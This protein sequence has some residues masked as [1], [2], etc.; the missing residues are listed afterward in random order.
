MIKHKIG[1]VIASN[2]EFLILERNPSR[3]TGWG[4][5]TGTMED[6]EKPQETLVRELYEELSIRLDIASIPSPLQQTSYFCAR[7][8]ITI[9]INWFYIHFPEQPH[10]T[11]QQ[12]E[13]LNYAWLNKDKAIKLLTWDSE[14]EIFQQLI[15]EYFSR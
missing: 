13:W 9:V 3:Y 6:N 5:V 8:N 12:E 1:I 7:K 4:L 11:I 10:L 14:K 15:T 2:N